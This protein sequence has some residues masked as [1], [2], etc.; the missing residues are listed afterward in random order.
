MSACVDLK[1]PLMRRRTAAALLSVST[2]TIDR[3][4]RAGKLPAVRVG[5]S[6]RFVLSDVEAFV[7]KQKGSVN[8]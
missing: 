7:A 1:A 6:I 4:V 5:G 2:T 3:L 8:E